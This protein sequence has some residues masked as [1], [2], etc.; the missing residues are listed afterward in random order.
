MRAR[1]RVAPV[2]IGV[3]WV[4]L[5]VALVATYAIPSTYCIKK[6]DPAS[7]TIALVALGVAIVTWLVAMFTGLR[8]ATILFLGSAA[9]FAGIGIV[10][11]LVHSTWTY[12]G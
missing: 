4:A 9:F 8:N 6:P 12:C 10:V 7:L 5:A 3:T 1:V 2:C 11:Y